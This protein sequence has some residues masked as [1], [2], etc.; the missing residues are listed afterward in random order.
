MLGEKIMIA[1]R[2]QKNGT[3]YCEYT[4][5]NDALLENSNLLKKNITT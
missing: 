1:K 2:V 5:N 4:T 3:R